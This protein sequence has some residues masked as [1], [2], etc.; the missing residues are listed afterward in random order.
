MPFDGYF[1]FGGNEIVNNERAAGYSRSAVCPLP[2]LRSVCASLPDAL[3]DGSYNARQ[4]ESAPWYDA[5][6]P[7]SSRF[8]G[9][10]ALEVKDMNTSTRSVALAEGITDGGVLGRSRKGPKAVRVRAMLVA[11][12]QDALEYGH[13]WLNSALDPGACG[14]HG[15]GCGTTD[16]RFFNACPPA[17]GVVR[18]LSDW[19]P[20]AVNH[21]LNPSFENASGTTVVRT[22]RIL[23]PSFET[24]TVG[25]TPGNAATLTWSTAQAHRG[26]ASMQVVTA[27]TT[28]GEGA[29]TNPGAGGAII[30][31]DRFSVG[32]WILA[33]A[34]SRLE[35]IATTTGSGGS[36]PTIRFTGTGAWQYIK[37]ENALPAAGL[38][39]YLV[40]RTSQESG[41]APQAITFYIDEALMEYAPALGLYFDGAS[42]PI[43]R[44][45]IL[46]DPSPAALTYWDA[47]GGSS[48]TLVAGEVTVVCPGAAANEGISTYTAPA[49]S[50]EAAVSGGM[51]VNAPAG[52]ALYIETR[53][54]SQSSGSARTN[55]T[56]TGA[57][58][59]VKA[60]GA[61]S[62]VSGGAHLVMVRTQ[63]AQAVTFKVKQ[64]IIEVAPTVG[65]YFDGAGTGVPSGFGSAWTG[66]A[67]TTSSIMWDADFSTRWAGAAN[68]SLSEL[69]GVPV[70]GIS[71]AVG[72]VAI[73][74]FRNVK[75]GSRS[76]RLIP[77]SQSSSTSYV[78]LALGAS[79]PA[80]PY[81]AM[82]T[83]TQ[84]GPI[85]GSL[86]AAR[87]R[88]YL[89]PPQ[90]LSPVTSPNA[91]GSTDHSFQV[92]T[93]G[94]TSFVLPH[95]G[96][97]GSGD[98]WY[99]AALV[100][101]GN[102]TSVA[103]FNGDTP[104]DPAD[105]PLYR[106][107]WTGTPNNSTSVWEIRGWNERPQTDEEY[108]IDWEKG[109][110]YLHDVA[111]TSGPIERELLNVD[112]WWGQVVEWTWT[113]ERP[114]IYGE[115]RQV[116]LPTTPSFVVEDVRYNRVPY[117]SME[118]ATSTDVP[119]LYNLSTNPSVET[120]ATDW[121]A[122]SISS[123]GVP[124][125]QFTGSR[126]TE[127]AAQGGAS[128]RVQ[129]L[130]NA[131]V[132][133]VRSDS[134]DAYQDIPLAAFPA[135]TRYSINIWAALIKI[136]GNA[137][138]VLTNVQ[139]I[140]DWRGSGGSTSL[141]VDTIGTATGAQLNGNVFQQRNILPPTGASHARVIIRGTFT[142][143][144]GNA[145]AGDRADIRLYADALA[146][147]VP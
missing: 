23:N 29:Y 96:L 133:A 20:E 131:T 32:A 12:G 101:L 3:G 56:G 65:A 102:L 57:W 4:M 116:D 39:P 13:G 27:G 70:L 14:Q 86:W 118:I 73:Q 43:V 75:A 22:Q 87:G 122:R 64:G 85:T 47:V 63:T 52:A 100:A 93:T 25:W 110:R 135:R 34:G 92:T 41:Q 61:S 51:W 46:R 142:W 10:Y 19:E 95:G 60:E 18:E 145:T 83:L 7:E 112:N 24:N 74:S 136:A 144:A 26:T 49:G 115:G 21:V 8:Y 11:D 66:P 59:F 127:L 147:S 129:V 62:T 128:Y 76:M 146:L 28:V 2:R 77:I 82:V 132:T 120:N 15:T 48:R 81:T 105:P 38:N 71:S 36:P 42:R 53:A 58:Q 9:L 80:G 141:R 79:L 99:D 91:A 124:V 30:A 121:N 17:R 69:T 117:P 90:S 72:V 35:V 134:V 84:E 67:N 138:N 16:L 108:A 126:T 130:G 1:T 125:G 54:N 68:N 119:M 6:V 94:S 123:P 107:R 50:V 5:A 143:E 104:G 98:V 97:V 33:P 113:S 88:P 89:T 109:V 44:S 139:A 137:N 111:T 40:I 106:Y 37:A 103:A 55:F 140:I 45:N 114:W 78:N 31:T